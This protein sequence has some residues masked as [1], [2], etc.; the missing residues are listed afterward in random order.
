[1]Q[2]NSQ[3]LT[4]VQIEAIGS[5]YYDQLWCFSVPACTRG[6]NN[7]WD[8]YKVVVPDSSAPQIYAIEECGNFQMDA[9]PDFNNTYIGFK[10]GEDSQYTLS[11]TV[12][13]LS[14]YYQQ[15]Y[16]VDLVENK[17]IDIYTTG[18]TYTF[19]VNAATDPLKRFQLITSLPVDPVIPP[20]PIDTVVVVVVP[21]VPV[22][23]VVIPPVPVVD[24][25]NNND[26][27]DSKDNKDCKDNK[28]KKDNKDCKDKNDKKD[29]K[30]CKDNKEKNDN[31]LKI[32]CSKRT[33]TIDNPG[34]GKGKIKIYNALTGRITHDTQFNAD[35]KTIIQSNAPSG[36]YV[37][38]GSNTTEK[39]SVSVIIQ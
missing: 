4:G 9:I 24:P 13:N 38:E 5:R 2:A 3:D 21:P 28:D 7:G 23:T 1:M 8:A 36:T 35:G 32:T 39:V 19:T 18:T 16:L 29:N 33:I 11:F 31:K 37:I 14:M 25:I 20:V 27:H 17:T 26:N 22:D 34:K 12:Q 10:P 6:F 15:L 30:D